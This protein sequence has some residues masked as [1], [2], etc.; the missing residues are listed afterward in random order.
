MLL[1]DNNNDDSIPV[2]QRSDFWQPPKIQFLTQVMIKG[3]LR[4]ISVTKPKISI[5][6][7]NHKCPPAYY[8]ITYRSGMK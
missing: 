6:Q 2:T 1:Y 7:E 3:L 4:K 5:S 8:S